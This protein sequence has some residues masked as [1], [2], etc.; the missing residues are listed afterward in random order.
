MSS[1]H[2]RA[3]L[4]RYAA[5]QFVVLVAAAMVLYPG[6]TWFDPAATRYELA[7]NFLS[8]LGAT[9]VFSG[10]ANYTSAAL[11]AIALATLGGALV[12]F[13]WAWRAYAL[14][15]GRSGAAGIASA[16]FGTGSGVA[17]VGVAVAPIDRVLVL[18]NSL[19]TAAFGL[20]LGYAASLTLLMWRARVGRLVV[21]ASYVALVCAYFVLVVVGLQSGTE[22][23]FAILVVGQKL[24][25]CASML[26]ILY[27]TSATRR[28]LANLP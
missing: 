16:L 20:L 27:V 21:N 14:E 25:V 15:L 13:A 2:R 10:R 7:R 9:H 1:L 23:G 4:L 22:H 8:D 5:L 6:G 11:F 18:H 28:A 17:F 12:A 26:H 3:G 19:V 24:I